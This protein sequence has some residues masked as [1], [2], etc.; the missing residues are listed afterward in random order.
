MLA[1]SNILESLDDLV[2][3]EL[4][5]AIDRQGQVPAAHEPDT[6]LELLLRAAHDAA[7]DSA[8]VQRVPDDVGG[9]GL[10]GGE[11]ADERDDASVG[12]GQEALLQSALAGNLENVVGAA[13]VG[14]ALHLSGPVGGLLVVDDVV[15]AELGLGERELL[16]AR[17]GDDRGCSRCFGDDESGHGYAAG[18]CLDERQPL[19]M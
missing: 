13:A 7:D 17:G 6:L 3:G 16:V 9:L 4:E 18:A 14:D 5:S 19:V 11:E 8:L 15:D 1:S 10:G 2:P 12:G